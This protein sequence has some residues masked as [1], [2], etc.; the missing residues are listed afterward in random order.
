VTGDL[1]Q[2][3]DFNVTLRDAAGQPRTF[4]RSPG[5]TV[6][7]D[8]PYA[9]HVALLERITDTQIHDV[10]AYLWTLK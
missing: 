6:V 9:A 1:V 3:D 2:M 5:V 10:V 7:K 8:D 4:R